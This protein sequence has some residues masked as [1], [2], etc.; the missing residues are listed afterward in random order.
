MEAEKILPHQDF[1][2]CPE[3]VFSTI[4]GEPVAIVCNK[5]SKLNICFLPTQNT[6]DGVI[7]C[8]FLAPHHGFSTEEIGQFCGGN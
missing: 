4:R 3:A 7:L 6:K 1:A 5:H 8:E 2:F